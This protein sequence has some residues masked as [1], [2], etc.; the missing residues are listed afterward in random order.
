[1]ASQTLQLRVKN[2]GRDG[3]NYWDTCGVLFVNTNDQG[4]I[5][6]ISVKHNMFPTVEMV[7]FPRKDTEGSDADVTEEG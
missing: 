5:T 6:S 4:G 7:A 3:K 1:M 2:E